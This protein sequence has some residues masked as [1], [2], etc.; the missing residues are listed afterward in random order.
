MKM[1]KLG[2]VFVILLLLVSQGFSARKPR[3]RYQLAEGTQVKTEGKYELEADYHGDLNEI[4]EIVRKLSIS[5]ICLSKDELEI[6]ITDASDPERWEFPDTYPFPRKGHTSTNCDSNLDY[7]VSVGS[8]PFFISVVRPDT[9]EVLWDSRESSLVYTKHYV[10]YGTGLPSGLVA[11]LAERNTDFFLKD[12]TYTVWPQNMLPNIDEGRAG[13]Q[14]H[15][16]HPVVLTRSASSKRFNLIFFRVSNG[17]DFS[18]SGMGQNSQKA[19]L[20]VEQAG[21]VVRMRVFVGGNDP[22][23]LIKRYHEYIG[24]WKMMPFWAFGW[25]QSRFGASSLSDVRAVEE[26]YEQNSL[27]LESIHLELDYL[28]EFHNFEVNQ[29]GFPRSEIGEWKREKDIKL[30]VRVEAGISEAEEEEPWKKAHEMDVLFKWENKTFVG[31]SLSGNVSWVDFRHPNSTSFWH[32]MLR[33]LYEETLF[34]GL[35]LEANEYS[36]FCDG[37]CDPRN[38]SIYMKM[39]KMQQGDRWEGDEKY[40]FPVTGSPLSKRTLPSSVTHYT[41]EKLANTHSVF[42]GFLQTFVTEDFLK[43]EL[44]QPHAFLM[45]RM[46]GAGVQ[47]FASHWT[48]DTVADVKFLELSVPTMLTQG[49]VGNAFVGI[50]AFAQLETKEAGFISF[51]F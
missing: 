19:H 9:S 50:F 4:P 5:I 47:Q 31:E 30:V 46:N 17:M 22:Q 24:K 3:N 10:Q 14:M 49:L 44:G 2:V 36:S 16:W 34:D 26:N 40:Y 33:K 20:K 48:G 39:A 12:G 42:L 37:V 11:G 38:E 1:T 18:L 35:F 8:N 32:G 51:F 23:A 13:S 28:R 21:G 27:P 29:R 6:S 41:G 43:R 15:G 7:R 25:H 45:S